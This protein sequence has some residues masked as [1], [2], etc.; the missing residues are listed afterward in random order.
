MPV[1][2]NPVDLGFALDGTD[3]VS[4]VELN[5]MTEL[6]SNTVGFLEMSD[7]ST[8]VGVMQYSDFVTVWIRFALLSYWITKYSQASVI[9]SSDD[10]NI[11]L[12]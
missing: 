10:K 5:L 4:Q 2:Q 7:S 3:S 6:V 1:C 12:R 11:F 8:R 9:F